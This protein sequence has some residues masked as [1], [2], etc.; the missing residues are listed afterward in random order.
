[1]I[2][3]FGIALNFK[4][5]TIAISNYTMYHLSLL[6]HLKLLFKSIFEKLSSYVISVNII[7]IILTFTILDWITQV[8]SRISPWSILTNNIHCSPINLC[9]IS[10]NLFEHITYYL[11]KQIHLCKL[12]CNL[13][14]YILVLNLQEVLAI[15]HSLNR[16]KLYESKQ[17][18]KYTQCW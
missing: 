5:C 14:E 15:Y 2:P 9:F 18:W 12:Q 4:V 1:M 3:F 13:L 7:L 17:H 6:T 8:C 11:E 10:Q 16:D